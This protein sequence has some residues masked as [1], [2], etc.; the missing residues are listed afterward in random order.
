[1]N[2]FLVDSVVPIVTR[3]L[4]CGLSG[5][6]IAIFMVDSDISSGKRYP[7]FK[8]LQPGPSLKPSLKIQTGVIHT[9]CQ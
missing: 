8:Q 1:M 2:R 5:R 4:A 6:Y 9:Y 3:P 7:A